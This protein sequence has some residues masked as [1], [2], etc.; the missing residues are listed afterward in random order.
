M[1]FSLRNVSHICPYCTFLLLS[2]SLLASMSLDF[3][4]PKHLYYIKFLKILL[5]PYQL[6]FSMRPYTYTGSLYLSKYKLLLQTSTQTGSIYQFSF[7]SK[8]SSTATLNWSYYLLFSAYFCIFAL[9]KS[10]S[11]FYSLFMVHLNITFSKK[12]S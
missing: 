1:L 7:I 3:S 4:L 8:F 6:S 5:S 11:R 12:L 9:L 10:S 2:L